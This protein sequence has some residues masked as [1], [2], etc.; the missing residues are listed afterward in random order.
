MSS[1]PTVQPRTLK[2][3]RDFLPQTSTARHEMTEQIIREARLFGFQLIDTPA[4]EYLET[5]TGSSGEETE[6]ELYHFEDHGGRR[7]GLRFDLTVPFARFLAEHSGELILPFKKVQVGEV[8][9]GEKPQKGRYRQFCQADLDIVGVDSLAAD[10]E[11]IF[12]LMTILKKLCPRPLTV[13]I[14]NRKLLSVVIQHYLKQLTPPEEARVLIAIDKLTK[15]SA[16]DVAGLIEVVVPGSGAST[17]ALLETISRKDASGSTDFSAIRQLGITAPG[18]EEDM[19]RFEATKKLLVDLGGAGSHCKV[20]ADLSIAR[21]LGYYTGVVFETTIDELPGFGSVSSGG[22]YNHL[23]ARFGKQEL[24]G[25]GGSIGVDRLLAALD[26][27]KLLPQQVAPTAFIAIATE[28]ARDYGFKI[29]K[30]LRDKNI[31]ADI[32]LKTTKLGNQFKFANRVGYR[33]VITVGDDEMTTGTCSIK[34]MQSGQEEKGVPM[35]NIL[36]SM[37]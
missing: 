21:G 12:S 24:E 30:M 10:V 37:V 25:V 19:Q 14:G 26:E 16:A 13:S 22:R 28:S 5:L 35:A 1:Q 4:L 17:T 7:V 2:G 3:F 23:V 33:K 8:W 36:L 11:V 32:C 31:S 20:R 34:D 9:R 15:I 27:M 6:K 18:F 29:L